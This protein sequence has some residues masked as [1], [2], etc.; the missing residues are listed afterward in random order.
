MT[1]GHTSSATAD[2]YAAPDLTGHLAREGVAPEEEYR[3]F[4]RAFRRAW[5]NRPE[6]RRTAWFLFADRPVRIRVAGS[7]LA[8][9]I[10]R[11][12]SHLRT[13]EME[14][15]LGL[16]VDMWD[17]GES[18]VGVEGLRPGP[19][20]NAAGETFVSEDARHVVTARTQTRTVHDRKK[21]HMVGWVGSNRLL[22]QYELGRPLHSELILWH[23]EQGVHAV[24]SGLVARNGNGVLFGGPG[25][26]GKSTTALTCLRAGFEYLA[27]DYV[28]LRAR[29]DGTFEGHSLYCSTHIEPGHLLRFPF[30]EAHARP[31]RLPREDKSLVILSEVL[32]EGLSRKARIRAVALP[33]VVGGPRTTL[34]PASKVESLLRLAPSS[35]LI[36]PYAGVAAREFE[37]M[38]QFLE[39]TPTY[40]LD[41]G[42]DLDEIPD[43]IQMLL[44]RHS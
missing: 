9:D 26:S 34:R 41:L 23:K 10:F 35:L 30:L 37:K 22:T 39:N 12:L 16:S 2:Q 7:A 27:D 4:G 31:G 40:W 20:L 15:A 44:D 11:P 25:G 29:S 38:S 17:Q 19:D 24:H 1:T 8:E 36:L 33:R 42:T 18:G 32:P 21:N 28:G 43:C 3:E 5:E 14:S 6:S 13:E